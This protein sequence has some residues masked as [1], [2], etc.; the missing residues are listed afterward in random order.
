MLPWEVHG[1]SVHL[2]NLAAKMAETEQV[3]IIY[4][5]PVCKTESYLEE[6]IIDNIPIA[7]VPD[8]RKQQNV[9]FPDNT[10]GNWISATYSLTQDWDELKK[11]IDLQNF[12]IVHFQDYYSSGLMPLFR[13]L[14]IPVV[15]TV[16]ALSENTTHFSNGIRMWM[17]ANSEKVITVSEWEKREIIARGL[18]DEDK[19]CTIYNGCEGIPYLKETRRFI[20]FAGR[21]E[22]KKGCDIFIRAIKLIN[23]DFLIHNGYRVM[24]M[25]D[26][27]ERSHL[28]SYVKENK[29]DDIICF[30]GLLPHDEVLKTLQKSIVHVVPSRLEPFGLSAVESIIE[31]AVTI[32]SDVDGLVEAVSDN[33]LASVFPVGDV[34]TLSKLINERLHY[35]VDESVRKIESEKISEKF[36][37]EEAALQTKNLYNT[38]LKSHIYEGEKS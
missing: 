22:Y 17:M 38:V 30:T 32:V 1:V 8:M 27:S 16:H 31:G 19:L 37:W 6:K 4:T 23:K 21:L 29:L 18:A 2:K 34:I 3:K 7:I 24:I 28:E 25:G 10:M 12:D 36:S 13:D 33:R 5:A 9:H 11:Y 14:K 20:T 35:P 26:G 15:S